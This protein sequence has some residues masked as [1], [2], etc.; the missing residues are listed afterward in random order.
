M[1]TSKF[2]TFLFTPDFG[3]TDILRTLLNKVAGNYIILERGDHYEDDGTITGVD[4][5]LGCWATEEEWSS[6]LTSWKFYCDEK[7]LPIGYLE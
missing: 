5:L 1:S 2:H 4:I 7:N 3:R 6:I